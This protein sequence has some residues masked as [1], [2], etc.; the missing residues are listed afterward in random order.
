MSCEGFPIDASRTHRNIQES[1]V[2]VGL[3][4][5]LLEMATQKQGEKKK[6]LDSFNLL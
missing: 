1:L 2:N 4:F 3:G 6:H 5:W